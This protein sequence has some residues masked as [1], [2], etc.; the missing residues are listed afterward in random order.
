MLSMADGGYSRTPKFHHIKTPLQSRVLP[1]RSSLYK[2]QRHSAI[3]A[4]IG[5]LTIL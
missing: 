1:S 4:L 3:A 5:Y 2:T